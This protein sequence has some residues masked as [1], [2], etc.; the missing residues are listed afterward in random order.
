MACL[1]RTSSCLLNQD[2]DFYNKIIIPYKNL[3]ISL[4]K[5]CNIYIKINYYKNGHDNQI[6]E[7]WFSN[8]TKIGII[9]S[10]FKF[11]FKCLLD[12]NCY[13]NFYLI[14][15]IQLLNDVEKFKNKENNFFS[16]F[17]LYS[18]MGYFNLISFTTNDLSL[19]KN[20]YIIRSGGENAVISEYN[21]QIASNHIEKKKLKT[22]YQCLD[23]LTL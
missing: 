13:H 11:L 17:G 10:E 18:G 12:L 16:L 7:E 8:V 4:K 1:R 9:T 21:R 6:T 15:H 23:I 22:F 20:Y 2:Y 5:N 3:I 19:G 14:N